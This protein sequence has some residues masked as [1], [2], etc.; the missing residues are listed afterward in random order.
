M[1]ICYINK[2]YTCVWFINE[3]LNM[4]D[5]FLIAAGCIGTGVAIIH[6][7]L[8]QRLMINPLLQSSYGQEMK[9]QVRK[10]LPILLHFSTFF[11]FIGGISLIIAPFAFDQTERL[12]A[13][14]VVGGFYIFGA[15]G[16]LWGTK[17]RHP[18][19][20]LLTAS[21]ALIWSSHIFF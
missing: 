4:N 3:V 16:N 1:E 2:P 15:L 5:I 19:W 21:V 10:L 6:G 14:I 7:V 18:G 13:S 9:T 12:A 8:M 11:W 17:G 20:V